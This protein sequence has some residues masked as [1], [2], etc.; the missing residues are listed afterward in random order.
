MYP[1]LTASSKRLSAA[2]ESRTSG[3]KSPRTHTTAHH[4]HTQIRKNTVAITRRQWRDSSNRKGMHC[5]TISYQR[6]QPSKIF[7]LMIPG[8]VM[9]ALRLEVRA[10]ETAAQ[11]TGRL[12]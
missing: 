8:S 5:A 2:E 10:R 9:A 11:A 7:S 4:W 12:Q 3:T 6:Y 1:F